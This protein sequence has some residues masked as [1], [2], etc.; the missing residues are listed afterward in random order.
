M[1]TLIIDTTSYILPSAWDEMQTKHLLRLAQLSMEIHDLNE[2]RLQMFLCFTGL[3]VLRKKEHE[4]GTAK[5]FYF[6]HDDKNVFLVKADDIAYH[7]DAL[8]FLF[9][10]EKKEKEGIVKIEYYIDPKLTKNPF[11]ELT[12]NDKKY[13]GPADALT[14]LTLTEYIH[15]ETNFSMYRKLKKDQYLHNL[16]A[17]LYR[18]KDKKASIDK[19]DF[20]GD[21]REPFNDFV[22]ENR[23]PLFDAL[24]PEQKEVILFYYDGSRSFL[25]K[26]F[27]EVFT[28]SA[29]GTKK[30]NPFDQFMNLVNLMTDHDVTK[31]DKVRESFLYDVLDTLNSMVL[32]AK[33]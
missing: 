14:N 5:C 29:S 12:V 1:K 11:P 31:K 16:I 30:S 3:K 2:L 32:N 27:P 25:N 20:K 26:L 8:D 23:A 7:L 19:P 9:R 24:S 10:S 4:V 13:Y 18:P 28:V 33:K 6:Y 22:F 21:M 15:A 17:I